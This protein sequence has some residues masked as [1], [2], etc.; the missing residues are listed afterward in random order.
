[1]RMG[2]G[3]VVARQFGIPRDTEAGLRGSST[4]FEPAVPFRVA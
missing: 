1:L 3:N 2:S 4:T